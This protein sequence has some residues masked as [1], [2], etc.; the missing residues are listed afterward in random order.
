MQ[1]FLP[2]FTEEQEK[3][4]VK[5]CQNHDRKARG[6][7]IEHNLRLVAHIVRKY[8][9]TSVS[10]EDLMSIGTIGLCKAVDTYSLQKG[11]RLATYAARCIENE[12]L[13]VLRQEHKYA[14]EVS[15]FEPLGADKDGNEMMIVDIL[16]SEQP[17]AQD[18]AIKR[19]QMERIPKVMAACLSEK[20]QQ[21]LSL[22]YGL[23]GK[24]PMTQRDVAGRFGIS[25]SYVSRIEK[26]AIEK[27]RKKELW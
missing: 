15:L 1:P 2:P 11:N 24:E 27:M 22:R 19:E 12:I 17:L 14:R 3:E 8:S 25:R 16:E 23:W 4:C 10:T 9:G 26:K 21:I 18:I 13:M 6:Q 7:L 20:E 5:R